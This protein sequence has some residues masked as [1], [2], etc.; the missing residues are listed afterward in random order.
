MPFCHFTL[1]AQKPLSERYPKEL[2]RLGD[3]IRKKRLDLG[4]F[5]K[6]LASKIGVD[7]ASILNWEKNRNTPSLVFI[8]KI[9]EFLGYLPSDNT[10]RSFGEKITVFR[11]FLGLKQKDLA[12]S[13]G[14][15]PGTLGNWER[16]KKQPKKAYLEK[17]NAFFTSFSSGA[18]KP[19]E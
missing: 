8:P 19:G 10:A 1:K 6:E 9:I 18:L 2:K 11:R 16:D 13:L 7:E 12:R 15:D 3:H 4:L 17:L 5:Q 14:I